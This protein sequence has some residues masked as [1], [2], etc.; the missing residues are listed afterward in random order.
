MIRSFPEVHCMRSTLTLLSAAALAAI[1]PATLRAADPAPTAT[2]AATAPLVD[3]AMLGLFQPLP[4]VM[5][6]PERVTEA[7]IDLGRMLFH[8]PRLSANQKI[9]CNS[10]HTL[11][12]HG[13]DNEPTSPGH[14]GQRGARNSPTV[15]NAA[16]HFVQFWDGRA[17]DVEAQ[18]KGPVLNPVEMALPD[19][20]HVET[21]LRSIPGYAPLFAKAFPNEQEPV[22]FDNAAVAIGAFERTLV[23]PSRFDE[24]LAGEQKALTPE[25]QKGLVVFVQTGCPTCHAGPYLGGQMYQKAGLVKPWPSQK[26]QGRYEVTKADADRMMF[27]VPGLRNVA[28]TGPYFHDGSVADLKPAIRM[29]AAHQLGRD[30]S[31]A[32][33]DAIAAFLAAT[34]ADLPK[35]MV[36]APA[37]PPSGPDTPKP[38][39]G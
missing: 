15:L 10:C 12:Q 38:E 26:D 33:V 35:S 11:A 4:E 9:S 2:P 1:L 7:R 31:D 24:F 19:A 16:G 20:Q 6:T 21:V 17:A 18:A 28:K 8:D 32:D 22:T 5:G 3:K 39:A 36:A 34:T 29:M 13:V 25:E 14:K 27:K 23:T 37:L 30:L